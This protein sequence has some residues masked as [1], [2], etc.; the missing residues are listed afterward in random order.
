MRYT[1]AHLFNALHYCNKFVKSDFC[2]DE[3]IR[4]EFYAKKRDLIYH[5]IKNHKEFQINISECRIELQKSLIYDDIN[6]LYAFAFIKDGAVLKVHQ[7]KYSKL[8]DLLSIL[9]INTDE[10]CEYKNEDD[11][12]LT[13]NEEDFSKALNVINKFYIKWRLH[14]IT[15][16]LTDKKVTNKMVYDSYVYYYPD[17]SFYLENGTQKIKNSDNVRIKYKKSKKEHKLN[18]GLLRSQGSTYLKVWREKGVIFIL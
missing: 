3:G 11:D 5:M 6:E 17:F 12:N 10:I 15:N 1:I 13:F 4:K 16:H 9:N 8:S 2:S 14:H 7:K 18:I